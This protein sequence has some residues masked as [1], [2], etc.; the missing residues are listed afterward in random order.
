M[1]LPTNRETFKER[2]LRA[3]GHPVIQINVDATQIDD[4]VDEAL[5]YWHDYHFDGSERV[6]LAH[7]VTEA[8]KTNKYLT[9]DDKYIGVVRVFEL[10]SMLGSS[11][12]FSLAYQFAQSDFLASALSGSIVPYWMAMTHIE[13]IQQ[14]LMGRQPVRF[15]RHMD[16]LHIDMDWSRVGV[17]DYVVIE[18]YEKADPALYPDVWTDRWLYRYCTQLI[19]RDWGN[20]LKKFGNMQMPGGIT[21]NGQ[22]IYEEAV[23]EIAKME[24]EMIND[25]SIPCIDL[26]G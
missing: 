18:A 12:L 16:K 22:Q 1:A 24:E 15:N 10:A 13:L 8:D 9:I 19:K 23:T 25:F 7:Q 20:N 3:L 26:M 5:Q 21:F 11:N 17:G 4:C 6:Y 14:V 2:C